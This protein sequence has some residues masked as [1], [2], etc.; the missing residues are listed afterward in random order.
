M[1]S[2]LSS[3]SPQ[4]NAPVHLLLPFAACS[5][6]NWLSTLK[7]LPAEQTRHFS[8]LLQDMTAW[9]ADADDADQA[10]A[11][12]SL[13][14]P[15]ERAVARLAGLV[16]RRLQDGLIPW[17]ALERARQT[18]DHPDAAD[19]NQAWAIVTP[20]HWTM[21]RE[22][23][24]LADPQALGLS[25][26]DSQALMAAMQP[27]CQEDGIRLHYLSPT[28]WLAAGEVFRGLPTASL[29]RVLGRD[30]D[31]WLPTATAK[32][33]AGVHAGGKLLRRLQNEMQMLLYTHPV[34]EARTQRRQL[35]VNSVWFSGTGDLPPAVV[36]KVNTARAKLDAVQAPRSL[37]QAALAGDWAA[38]GAAWA[39]LDTAQG[40]ELLARQNAGECVQLTLCGER[41]ARTF[42]S[43]APSL[44]SRLAKA[45]PLF[46]SPRPL[47]AYLED[48]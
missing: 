4:S 41:S 46:F 48:L 21:G 33:G 20:C 36:A 30:V 39:A 2:A 31:P 8:A 22:R 6:D 15:H 1:T 47:W 45:L 24:T 32:L 11:T 37:A 3:L 44:R 34:N 29:D 38:Y 7:A 9:P 26:A 13:S 10:D 42:V 16:S 18:T 35:P 14:P 43:A 40:R 5:D 19:L 23:A 17:A 28:K 27:Y 25:D 12:R